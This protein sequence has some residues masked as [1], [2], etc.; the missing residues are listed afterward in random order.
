M[1]NVHVTLHIEPHSDHIICTSCWP[2]SW[3]MQTAEHFTEG[4]KEIRPADPEICPTVPSPDPTRAVEN[5]KWD[6][7]EGRELNKHNL[8]HTIC[9]ITDYSHLS[10]LFYTSLN[11]LPPASWIPSDLPPSA[12]SAAQSL[13]Q[14]TGETNFKFKIQSCYILSS[15]LFQLILFSKNRPV[16]LIDL[17]WFEVSICYFSSP[18]IIKNFL[19][20]LPE[21]CWK[22]CNSIRIASTFS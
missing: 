18:T 10:W 20:I 3:Q 4:W 12:A 16:K 7:W 11:W 17:L 15:H 1:Y 9:L 6:R 19:T 21:F 8:S 14:T 2:A 5:Y 22:F 13:H